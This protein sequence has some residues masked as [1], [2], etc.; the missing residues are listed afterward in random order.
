MALW[1]I[2]TVVRRTR[3]FGALAGFVISAGSY[4]FS[5]PYTVKFRSFSSE[6][7]E[8][9]AFLSPQQLNSGE[10]DYG[11]LLFKIWVISWIS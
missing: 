4:N 9:F 7:E 2:L 3:G 8:T 6:H 1:L 11:P 5:G 10:Y